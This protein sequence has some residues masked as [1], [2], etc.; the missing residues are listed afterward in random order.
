M[1]ACLIES[2]RSL[3]AKVERT[4]VQV[5]SIISS[6]K[7][8]ASHLSEPKRPIKDIGRWSRQHRF[9]S[10]FGHPEGP[11]SCCVPSTCKDSAPRRVNVKGAVKFIKSSSHKSKVG[12]AASDIFPGPLS[13]DPNWKAAARKTKVCVFPKAERVLTPAASD[14]RAALSLESA[15]KSQKKPKMIPNMQKALGRPDPQLEFDRRNYDIT[16]A[17]SIGHRDIVPFDKL[18]G[19]TEL[20]STQA[21]RQPEPGTYDPSYD[22]VLPRAPSASLALRGRDD[23]AASGRRWEGNVLELN[24]DYDAVKP[25]VPSAIINAH[26]LSAKTASGAACCDDVPG[27]GTYD[28]NFW[29]VKKSVTGPVF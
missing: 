9:A 14:D 15:T 11:S 5:D 17:D 25:C 28:P 6:A 19:R 29:F 10:T 1:T 7:I 26:S 18:V 22:A 23:G 20:M 8:P 3:A 4:N 12:S 27:V 24:P 13:Y 16:T 21:F 2:L